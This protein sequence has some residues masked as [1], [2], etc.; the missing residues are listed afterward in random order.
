MDSQTAMNL[1]AKNLLN[2]DS[3]VG[4]TDKFYYSLPYYRDYA[5]TN[6]IPIAPVSGNVIKFYE[7]RMDKPIIIFT[8]VVDTTAAP[9]GG[10]SV[11]GDDE[12]GEYGEE[13]D[14]MDAFYDEDGNLRE[15]LTEE[16]MAALLTSDAGGS[17][18]TDMDDVYDKPP[19]GPAPETDTFDEDVY[20][21]EPT[22]GGG[23][24]WTPE[25]F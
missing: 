5:L 8:D 25:E 15:D 12:S 14:S 21:K 3:H 19:S 16:E 6:S 13:T 11:G 22:S 10:D 2:Y 4:Q 18:D 1:F 20:D 24:A 23:E 17:D 7:Y 9:A